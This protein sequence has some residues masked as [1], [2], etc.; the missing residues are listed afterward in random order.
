MEIHNNPNITGR[1]TGEV[2]Q[3][4]RSTSA[5]SRAADSATT[6]RP[7]GDQVTL[8]EAAQRLLQRG[9]SDAG[10]PVNEAR[11][12][13]LRSAIAN[14]NYEVDSATIANRLV[15]GHNR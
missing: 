15:D 3:G 5:G 6:A 10:A 4:N 2:E 11:V 1:T 9:E 12:A 14:G 7:H 13:A 8:T